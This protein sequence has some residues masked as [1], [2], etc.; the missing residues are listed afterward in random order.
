[1]PAAD[2]RGGG[3]A[4]RTLAVVPSAMAAKAVSTAMAAEPVSTA[5]AA[6]AVSTA[7]AKAVTAQVMSVVPIAVADVMM[8]VVAIEVRRIASAISVT[9]R[10]IAVACDMAMMA[11]MR[12][13]RSRS[14]KSNQTESPHHKRDGPEHGK[15]P[16]GITPVAM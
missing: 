10:Q 2:L 3:R 1:M 12:P 4:N 7:V 11:M 6:E 15:P 8:V 5:M 9:E 16:L 14:R 13:G